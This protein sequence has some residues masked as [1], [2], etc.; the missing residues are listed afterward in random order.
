MLKFLAHAGGARAYLRE[1]GLAS[2]EIA[3]LRARL[4]E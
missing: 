1:I 4:R 3:A 2:G